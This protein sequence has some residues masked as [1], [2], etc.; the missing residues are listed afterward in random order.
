[1]KY[2]RDRQKLAAKLRLRAA[3]CLKVFDDYAER[4]RE[5]FALVADLAGSRSPWR[6]EDEIALAWIELKSGRVAA[7]ENRLGA[8][9][10]H[11]RKTPPARYTLLRDLIAEHRKARGRK[12][13][14]SCWKSWIA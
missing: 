2:G 6:D 14:D 3:A 5:P 9:S 4:W 10:D 12:V 7:A 11:R 1:M 13:P 8:W